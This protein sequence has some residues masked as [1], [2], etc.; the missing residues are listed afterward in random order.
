[1]TFVV[2]RMNYAYWALIKCDSKSQ[3]K[4]NQN[5]TIGL[6]HVSPATLLYIMY[7][8]L[9]PCN[10]SLTCICEGHSLLSNDRIYL[11]RT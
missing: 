5:Q 6:R 4:Q 1:M 9:Y 10:H 3:T 8:L 7:R 11:V 2:I